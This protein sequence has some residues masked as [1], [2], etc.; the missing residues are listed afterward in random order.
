MSQK[1]WAKY[2]L[3]T[4]KPENTEIGWS[5]GTERG[6]SSPIESLRHFQELSSAPSSPKAAANILATSYKSAG[7]R[8]ARKG[9]KTRKVSRKTRQASRKNR[10]Y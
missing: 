2:F 9:R 7:K 3:A 10:R 1:N 5:P 6:R 8:K 4:G